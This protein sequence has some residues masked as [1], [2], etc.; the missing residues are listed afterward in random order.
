MSV[1]LN[2]RIDWLSKKM[3]HADEFEHK[4]FKTVQRQLN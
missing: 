4:M 2:V 1:I 3:F